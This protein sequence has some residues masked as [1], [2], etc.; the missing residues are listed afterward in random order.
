M[1]DNE[2]QTPYLCFANA[3][4]PTEPERKR[5][6]RRVVFAEGNDLGDLIYST[7]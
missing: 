7:N 5:K 2:Q 4:L 3:L 1:C 6:D